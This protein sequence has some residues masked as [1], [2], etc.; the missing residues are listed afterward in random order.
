MCEEMKRHLKGEMNRMREIQYLLKGKMRND[1]YISLQTKKERFR[2]MNTHNTH[3]FSIFFSIFL[4][5]WRE[6]LWVK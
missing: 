2:E 3:S 1:Y 5:I 4:P 6:M